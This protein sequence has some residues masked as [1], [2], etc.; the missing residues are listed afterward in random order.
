MTFY[1]HIR[2][3][4]TAFWQALESIMEPLLEDYYTF[5]YPPLEV[6]RMSDEDYEKYMEGH[7]RLSEGK[8]KSVT[9]ELSTGPMTIYTN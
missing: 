8:E 6:R 2:Q 9:I 7:R 5:G 3:L 4:I 1:S